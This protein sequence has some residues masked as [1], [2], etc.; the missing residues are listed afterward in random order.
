MKELLRGCTVMLCTGLCTELK[1]T[2]KIVKQYFEVDDWLE[3]FT[4]IDGVVDTLSTCITCMTSYRLY[5]DLV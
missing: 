4:F 5:F 3:S 1:K 2:A